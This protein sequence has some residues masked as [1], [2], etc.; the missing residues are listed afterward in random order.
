MVTHGNVR[1]LWRIGLAFFVLLLLEASRTSAQGKDFSIVVLPD[2]QHYASKHFKVGLAQTEW[3][4]Q[5][6][7]KF[8]IK[9]VVSV[10]DNVDSG[11]LDT[12]FKRSVSFM[13]KLKGVVP[14][15][16]ACGNHDLLDGKEGTHTS[17][18]FVDYYGPQRFKKYSWYCGASES[19][20][21]SCQIFEGGGCKFLAIELAVSA[22]KAEISWAKEV[23]AEH[24]DLPVIL[25][26]HQMLDPEGKIGKTLAAG[27]SGRQSPSKIWSN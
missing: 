26:T 3:I 15:G 16:V 8:Q 22:P 14:Y 9:F 7:E 11:W 13:D 5:N 6:A 27:G 10:G 24:P 1:Q 19:G 12:E 2:P 25:T 17:L 4:C 18:K 23:I 21:S 20:F